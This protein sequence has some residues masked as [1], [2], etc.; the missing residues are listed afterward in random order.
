MG[1]M[2]LEENPAAYQEMVDSII[3]LNSD[4]QAKTDPELGKMSRS[5]MGMVRK[6]T[7]LDNLMIETQRILMTGKWNDMRDSHVAPDYY[8]SSP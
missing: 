3:Q 4:F 7:Y 5:L 2:S 8:R 6:D 1:G